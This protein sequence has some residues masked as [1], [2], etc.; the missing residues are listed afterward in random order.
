MPCLCAPAK[1]RSRCFTLPS[2]FAPTSTSKSFKHL[3]STSGPS[4]SNSTLH[5]KPSYPR[6][7]S[8]PW[9]TSWKRRH[10]GR[11]LNLRCPTRP[12][13][14]RK[15]ESAWPH[16]Q[17]IQT[18]CTCWRVK[19]DQI[20]PNLPTRPVFTRNRNR[21]W[22]RRWCRRWIKRCKSWWHPP[23]PKIIIT[24]SLLPPARL[25]LHV[26]LWLT[27]CDSS[28]ITGCPGCLVLRW[29]RDRDGWRKSSKFHGLKCLERDYSLE[30]WWV[31]RFQ[32]K[33]GP[34]RL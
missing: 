21:R 15:T 18:S 28:L 1:Q 3:C 8:I 31:D 25:L 7:Q 20:W 14:S 9:T 34:V 6:C 5:V 23:S 17:Q 10:L 19:R 29:A 2:H 33:F 12:L 13:E 24:V 22:M 16:Q 4:K 32:G 27:Y 26:W 11:W 30:L